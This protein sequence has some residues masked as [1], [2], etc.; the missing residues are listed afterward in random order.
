MTEPA[1]QSQPPPLPRPRADWAWFL[2]LDGTL[3]DIAASPSHVDVPEGLVPTL[4]S[5]R[6]AA[7]GA[8]AVVSGRQVQQLRTLLEPL[9]PAA[10][11]L[12]GLE[13]VT[14]DGLRHGTKKPLP[15]VGNLRRLLQEAVAEIPGVEFENKGPALAIHYRQVP[16]AFAQLRRIVDAAAVRHRG[17][18]LLEGKMVFE[19]RP[20][21]IHKGTAIREFMAIPPFAGRV[22]FFAGDD[23]TDEDGFRMVHEMGG[24]SV[25]VGDADQPTAAGHTIESPAA[26]RLWL[27]EA[28][29]MLRRKP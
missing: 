23:R 15:P 3:L 22:P 12:H 25:R 9:R 5:L 1:L 6:A 20:R 2:D 13:I 24:L 19:F 21:D 29:E 18:E 8:L 14:P 16:S 28:A 27:A 26:L 7:H 4:S 11:G 10:A 17:F